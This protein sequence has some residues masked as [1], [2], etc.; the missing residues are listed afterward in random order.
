MNHT[1]AFWNEVDKIMPNYTEQQ[2]WLK[3]NGVGMDL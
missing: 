2:N 3:Y 1:Q